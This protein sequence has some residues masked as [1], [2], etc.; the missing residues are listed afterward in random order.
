MEPFIGI[1]LY[2]KDSI[3][4]VKMY[5]DAFGLTLGYHVLNDDGTFFHSELNKNGK[6]MLSVVQSSDPVAQNNPVHLGYTFDDK[7]ELLH[8]FNVLKNDGAVM[9]GLCELPWS[10][11]AAEIVDQFG[12]RWYLTLQQYRPDEEFLPGNFKSDTE[13]IHD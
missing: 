1:G 12:I 9:M 11:C 3:K 8:A 6:P 4:A 5:Q 10:P 7:E 2:V 13:K